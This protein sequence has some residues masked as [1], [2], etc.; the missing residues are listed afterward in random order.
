VV[1][2]VEI[3]SKMPMPTPAE[4]KADL[5]GSSPETIIKEATSALQRMGFFE[6]SVAKDAKLAN[7]QAVDEGAA[8]VIHV[9]LKDR[10]IAGAGSA[11]GITF[12][13]KADCTVY[14]SPALK[15]GGNPAGK[16]P[17]SPPNS[18]ECQSTPSLPMVR[19]TSEYARLAE[20][21][22]GMLLRD[23]C[24][25]QFAGAKMVGGKLQV[26]VIA[27]NNTA[28]DIAEIT[29]A[30]PTDSSSIVKEFKVL[31]KIA[32]GEKKALNVEIP[33]PAG[34]KTTTDPKPNQVYVSDLRFEGDSP[35]PGGK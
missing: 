31:E 5:L 21:V 32:P 18:F 8:Y 12:T 7:K 3:G 13:L 22:R 35:K 10:Q 34:T 19:G 28:R 20:R 17:Q 24:P 25:V 14:R 23:V 11:F 6:V 30:M 9:L 33:V 27:T 16:W 26:S 2:V 1:V 29:L 15:K 4:R